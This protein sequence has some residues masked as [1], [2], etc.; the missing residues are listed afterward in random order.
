MTEE[1]SAETRPKVYPCIPWHVWEQLHIA[2]KLTIIANDGTYECRPCPGC[3]KPM[4]MS[5]EGVRFL[6]EKIVDL[7]LCTNCIVAMS[8]GVLF[9]G[10]EQ[11]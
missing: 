8:N 4:M 7:A 2:I 10:K 9:I 3:E 5:P 1:T 11:Q 6:H